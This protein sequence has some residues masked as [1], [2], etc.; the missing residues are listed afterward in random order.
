MT[1]ETQKKTH[2]NML[3]TTNRL[4]YAVVWQVLR[5]SPT[6]YELPPMKTMS[7]TEAFS[8]AAA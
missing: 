5:K 6:T 7:S 8:I 4:A 3:K 1:K 2:P